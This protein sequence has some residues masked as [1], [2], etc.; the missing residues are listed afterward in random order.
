MPG[1]WTNSKMLVE[2]H[3]DASHTDASGNPV[4]RMVVDHHGLLLDL[5]KVSGHL[6]DETVARVTWGPDVRSGTLTGSG[7]VW[8]KDGSTRPFRD[9]E[10]LKPYLDAWRL[11]RRRV[12]GDEG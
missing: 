8:K 7:R 2:I 11:E 5:T 1:A 12:L 10:L 4:H 9:P 6:L 3:S